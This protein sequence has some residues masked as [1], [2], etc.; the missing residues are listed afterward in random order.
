[1]LKA[2]RVS[3][4]YSERTYCTNIATAASLQDVEK[5]YSHY[6]WYSIRLATPDDLREAER[7]QMPVIQCGNN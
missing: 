2:Y 7:K 5:E 4:Q 6:K 3:F 1:M